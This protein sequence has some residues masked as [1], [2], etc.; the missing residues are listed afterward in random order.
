M[1]RTLRFTTVILSAWALTCSAESSARRT[2]SLDGRWQVAEGGSGQ[3]PQTFDHEVPVPGLVDMATPPF[4]EPGPKLANSAELPQKD[5][6]REAFWYRRTFVVPEPIPAVATLKVGKAMFGTRVFLNGKLL[7]EHA[8]CFTPGFF[9]ARGALRSGENEVVIRVGADRAAV[10]AAVPSGFDFEKTRY[11][12]GIFDSVELILSG[13]PNIV[14][15]QVAPDVSN[16]LARVRVELRHAV[17]GDV[18]AEIREAKSGKVVG[19]ASARMTASPEQ[20][21][22]LAAAVS[23]C[24]L[25]SPESP[26]L[27]RLIVR[28]GG[29][30]FTTRFG[31]REFRFDPATGRAMLNGKPYFMRGSNITLYRFFEDSERGA[32]PWDGKWVRLLHQRVKE[33]HWNCL[34]YCIGFPPEVWYDIADEEGVLIDD[35]FP[36]WFGGDVPKDMPAG[37]LAAE[38]AEW[39]RER[40]NHPCVVIWDACNETLSPKTGE[41]IKQV[42]A[43]DLSNRPWDNGYFSPQEPGDMFESHPYHFISPDFKLANLAAADPIPQGNL[44]RNDGQHAAVINEYGWLWLN[45]DGTPTTLTQVLY[46]NLLGTNSTTELRRRLYARHTAAETEFWRCHRSAA[47]VIHFTALGYSRPDGQTS[48]HWLDVTKLTWEPEFQRYVRDAFAPVGLMIDVWDEDYLPGKM[49]SF[50][51]VIINDQSDSWKGDVVFRILRDGKSVCEQ[52]RQVEVEGLGLTNVVF[53][54]AIPDKTGDYQ[55]EAVLPVTP[56]GKVSSLRDF[57]VL[58]AA[59]REARR[60]LAKGR[61][62]KASSAVTKDGQAY[63]AELAVDGRGDTRWSSEFSDPQWLAVDL[64]ETLTFSRVRLAWEAAYAKAYAIQVSA[65]GEN[66]NTVY[67]TDTGAGGS[68][69]IRIAPTQARWVRIYGTQRGSAFGYSLWDIAIFH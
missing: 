12:P 8:P 39:M 32:L 38:Y 47:A 41:A 2:L 26:F 59:E 43:L 67:T 37:E 64:G 20:T 57:L 15:V 3:M 25:W 42:R 55:A 45:R 50:P 66:W 61:P 6:R 19:K 31:M 1:Q 52:R 10:T 48:D 34:R 54:V 69:A 49:Q 18:T 40:W 5:P 62:V 35:E 23:D 29:D 11:I 65:D 14:R 36:I 53:A 21:L 51:V 9:D 16:R 56:E 7:G 58:S 63:R 44:C 68:E 30:E 22:D 28:T 24:H 27:Y 46:R 13:T 17:D 60:D 33:M 4:A